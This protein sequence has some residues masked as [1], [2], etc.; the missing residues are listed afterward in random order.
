[1]SRL[2]REILEAVMLALI[3]LILVQGTVR[4]FKV[5]GSSMHPTLE[6][7]QYLVVDQVSYFKL[8][9]E[10]LARILPFWQAQEGESKFAFDPPNRGE[11]IVF[12]YPEDPTKDFV[13]RVVGV[14]GETVEVRSGTVF[15]DGVALSEPYL[16]SADRSDARQ[17]ILGP[18]EYYVIG[19]NRSN[20]NDSRAWGVVPEDN[21]VGRVLLVYWPWEDVHFVDSR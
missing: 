20:S 1:M 21:I 4:N 6:G 15:V 13:K 11:V 18:K 9:M 10:R 2:A 3:V 19:D 5:E 12:R 8:D 14:P 17:I 7:G 16:E